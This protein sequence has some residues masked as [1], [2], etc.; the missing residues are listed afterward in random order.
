LNR[1]IESASWRELQ[2][3]DVLHT[4]RLTLACSIA[5]RFLEISATLPFLASFWAL[6]AEAS[7][8]RFFAEGVTALD[9]RQRFHHIQNFRKGGLNGR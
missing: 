9:W 6:R 4:T 5:L 2:C 7:S 8:L 3:T 1:F